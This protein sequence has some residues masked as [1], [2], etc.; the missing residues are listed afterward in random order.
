MGTK[1][2]HSFGTRYEFK[3]V[4]YWLFKRTFPKPNGELYEGDIYHT[5]IKIND[6]RAF[7]KS[8]GKTSSQEAHDEVKLIILTCL[9]KIENGQ[10]IQSRKFTTVSEEFLNDLKNDPKAITSKLKK[11]TMVIEKYLNEFFG[12]KPMDSIDE[13]LIIEYKKWRKNYWNNKKSLEYSYERN[14]Q[15]IKSQRNYLKDKPVSPST[16]KKED[17]ILRQ[18]LEFG[19]LSGDI[20]SNRV[21][22]IKSET[23]KANRRPSFTEDE[24]KK[25]LKS[26][27]QRCNTKLLWENRKTS[28]KVDK[29][30]FVNGQTLIQRTLLHEYI[31]FMVGSGLRTTESTNLKW[32]DVIDNEIVEEVNGSFRTVKSCKLYVSGKGKQRKCDPQPYV[33]HILDRIKKRQV[34]FSK[35]NKFKFTGKDEYVWSDNEGNRIKSFSKGFSGLLDSCDLLYDPQG[36]KRVVGSLRHTYGTRRKN[37]GEVD[38]FEL[39]IQMGTSPE[40]ILQHYV[41]S[42]DYDRSTAVTR[43]KKSSNKK[44]PLPS[45]PRNQLKTRTPKKIK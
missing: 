9:L 14:G 28:S 2:N 8:T 1:P 41:H 38:T 11:H 37:L 36:D 44:G 35:Q 42:D 10:N 7:R 26:S 4:S 6:N 33:K 16:L 40:M 30:K 43:I 21:I 45:V 22:K 34:Q 23:F 25:V 19:R 12:I 32:S 20:S 15:V 31:N 3:D 24:W 13:K 18:V 5:K 17:V 27:S 39:A 29:N